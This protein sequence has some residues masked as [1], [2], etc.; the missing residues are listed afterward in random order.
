ME[1]G[2]IDSYVAKFKSLLYTVRYNETEHGI[3]S[4]FKKGLLNPL[5]IVIIC[6]TNPIPT[7]LKGWIK[8]ACN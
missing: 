3:L 5:N 4:I 8:A 2:N 6:Y 7:D 1:K